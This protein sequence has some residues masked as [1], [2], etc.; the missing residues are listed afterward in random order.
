MKSWLN[1]GSSFFMKGSDRKMLGMIA[2]FVIIFAVIIF[3]EIWIM[4]N[5]GLINNE[6][7]II[8]LVLVL[9]IS[10]AWMLTYI[11]HIFGYI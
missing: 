6:E 7:L 3:A 1:S 2:V 5:G 10:Y 9:S 8:M 11:I 4:N